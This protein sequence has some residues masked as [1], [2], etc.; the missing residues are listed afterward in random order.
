MSLTMY[1]KLCPPDFDERDR[2]LVSYCQAYRSL[3]ASDPNQSREVLESTLQEACF[4]SSDE[5]TTVTLMLLGAAHKALGN[6][7][8][9]CKFYEK[10]FALSSWE[11]SSMR[12][13]E[14]S[15]ARARG[16]FATRPC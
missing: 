9:V 7:E 5:I 16:V 15:M 11:T 8:E 6:K 1:A 10:A 12:V 14:A 2:V 4:G 13:D 3:T